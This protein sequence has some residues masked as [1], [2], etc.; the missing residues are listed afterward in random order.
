MPGARV[1]LFGLAAALLLAISSSAEGAE[2]AVAAPAPTGQFL[3]LSDVHF[4]PM[5]DP[6]L[7]DRLLPAEPEDWRGIFESSEQTGLSR[8][9]RDTNWMLLRSVL[10]QMKQALPDAQFLLLPGDFLAHNFRAAFDAAAKEHSDAAY[11]VFVRKT[12]LFLTQQLQR[13][14]PDR[15]ILPA[16]GNNDDVCG[17]FL[18][19]PGGPFL[20]DMLPILRSLVDGG[21]TSTSFDPGWAGYGNY[22]VKVRGIRVVAVNTVFFSRRYR[23]AC[24]SPADPDP[25]RA[26][27]AWLEGEL[28]AA[29]QAREPVWLL[30][31]V[32]PGIDGF[33]TLFRGSCPDDILPMWEAAYTEPFYVLLRRYADTVVTAFA[34]HTHMDD[35]RLIGDANG[36]YA[37][38][39]IM[40]AVSPIFGQNP[41]FRTVVY[42]AA[43]GILDQTTYDLT[44]LSE[45]SATGGLPPR[46]EREYTFTHQWNLPRVDLASI[47]RLYSLIRDVPAE[48]ERWHAIFA[49]SSPVYWPRVA[50]GDGG[51]VQAAR[52]FSCASGNV[53]LPDYRQ[54]YCGDN[55]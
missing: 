9:G 29:K 55:R 36:R 42:D 34:G 19:Q 37:F 7:M 41:G 51:E 12:M 39:L 18:L 38:A 11:R 21:G 4:D 30:Y 22:S 43:G 26:T 49:V 16:L 13:A 48:R 52:A 1:V 35:F 6:G 5:A 27:L 53:L 40:P 2:S 45:A 50:G 17:D 25:G 28:A 10:A 23:N 32:P 33:A 31:H 24:G 15:P 46:W 3:M 47:E 54:C 20:A 14:F 44:N 8:Y